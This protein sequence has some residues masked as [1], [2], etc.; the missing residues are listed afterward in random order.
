MTAPR[1]PLRIEPPRWMSEPATRAV[2]DALAAGGFEARF[3]GGVV[4][5]TLLGLPTGEPE[6]RTDI[7]LATPAP[8]ERVIELLQQR[9]IKVAPTGLAHGTV[10]AVVPSAPGMPPRHFEI[11]TLRRDVE[12][13]GRRARVAFDADWA[14]D[15]ARRDFTINA[16]FLSPDGT[17]DDPTGGL[18]DLAARRVRF[19][20]EPATRIIEDVLRIL[21]YYRFEARF[22]GSSSGDDRARAACRDLA[23]LL[24]TLSPERVAAEITRLLGTADPVRAVQMMAEDG[25]LG[26]I[27][28]EAR[29]LDRLR[30]MIGIER[31]TGLEP[32]PLRRLAA[33]IET[34]AAGARGLAGR[35]R[36]ANAWRD[37]LAELMPP[38]PLAPTADDAAQR[39]ALYRLGTARF[40]DLVLMQ[41][42]ENR[43]GRQRLE[44]LLALAD[45]WTPPVFPLSGHDVTALEVPPGP[46]V[47]ALLAAVEAWWEAADFAPDRGQ[48]LERLRELSRNFAAGADRGDP[49]AVLPLDLAAAHPKSGEKLKPKATFPRSGMTASRRS[50]AAVLG[51]PTD[52]SADSVG[53]I[54]AVLNSLVADAF[55][56]YVK[57]KNFH[58]H[59]SGSHFR[60]YHLM[61]DEQGDQIFAMTDIL[62]ERVRKIGGTTLRSIG[63][64]AKL[65][66]ITD[67][68]AE[69]VAPADMLRELMEDNKAFTI[70]MREAHEVASN[71]NDVATASLLEN[72][73]DET[74]KRTWYLFEATRPSNQPG[75]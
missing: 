31:M 73:I 17:I 37:R 70:S 60:D 10:T 49:A 6:A 32:D 3:V 8:P 56:L 24:P 43:I 50:A 14:E 16:I 42:A 9:G 68:D 57:T 15:A 52:L 69:F 25:V 39:R 23:Y 4:R 34:D 51:T 72:F 13:F 7:D 38:S 35:L 12:T 66:R 40:R 2:L 71:N 20:G 74:E 59:V 67:N 48:C 18:A 61:L 46:R 55:A 58:W 41:A 65:K 21:R 64:I 26:V 27:L 11:T 63:H 45:D 44:H 29:R 36:F 30:Q 75:S 22:G 5:D 62:A 47:G 1:P 33:L 54:T 28:P 19:V 53:S